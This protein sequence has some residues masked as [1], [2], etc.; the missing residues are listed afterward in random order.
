MEAQA[1]HLRLIRSDPARL[2]MQHVRTSRQTKSASSWLPSNC[3]PIHSRAAASSW[4]LRSCT[5]TVA[6]DAADADARRQRPKRPG[7]RGGDS[8]PRR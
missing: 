8:E 1:L 3:S 5:T 6:A 4:L 2:S 7:A